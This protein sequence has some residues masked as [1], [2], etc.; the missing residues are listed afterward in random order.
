MKIKSRFSCASI[1]LL[2]LFFILVFAGGVLADTYP[3]TTTSTLQTITSCTD[4]DGGKN[5]YEKGNATGLYGACYDKCSTTPKRIEECYCDE[6][7]PYSYVI[8]TDCPSG[9]DCKDGACTTKI[10][11]VLTVSGC[12]AGTSTIDEGGYDENGCLLPPIC[13]RDGK[14][15]GKENSLNCLADCKPVCGDGLCNPKFEDTN[16]CPQDCKPCPVYPK[17][18]CQNGFLMYGGSFEFDKE[19]KI[20]CVLSEICCGNGIC[21]GNTENSE[22]CPR[23]C[24]PKYCK[25]DSDCPLRACIAL[26]GADCS[27]YKCINN[28][29]IPPGC[30]D[31]KCNR[32][33][34]KENCPADCGLPPIKP[35]CT[36]DKDCPQIYCIKAP[37]PIN[38][39]INGECVVQLPPI[40]PVCGNNICEEGEATW[41]PECTAPPCPLAPCKL[42]TCPKDCEELPP[43][44]PVC[45][46]NICEVNEADYCP[47]GPDPPCLSGTCPEDCEEVQPTACSPVGIRTE[48]QYCDADGTLKSQKQANE[49]CLNNFE[50]DSNLCIS[51]SCVGKKLWQKFLDWFGRWF[52]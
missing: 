16:T 3:A 38:R 28:V 27:S 15:E 35:V 12:P 29:C 46:N 20:W 40:K 47:G 39:C 23:D 37:C 26:V 21:E 10:C 24:G 48:E 45:G 36:S 6:K 18:D 9:G 7:S 50:C 42:G 25:S 1:F 4:S 33:E 43:I 49:F 34:S 13:C 11:P 2:S 22:S 14:C 52:R 8:A 31:N 51:D 32:D 19:S 5:Y 30:G 17:P 41:C 44:K